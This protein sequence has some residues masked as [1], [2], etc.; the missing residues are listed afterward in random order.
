MM[1]CW[2]FD[3]SSRTGWKCSSELENRI[4]PANCRG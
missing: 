1:A 2:I 3:S 4:L